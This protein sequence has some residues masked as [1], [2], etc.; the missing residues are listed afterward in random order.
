M[1]SVRIDSFDSLRLAVPPAGFDTLYE[2]LVSTALL[3]TGT[4]EITNRRGTSFPVCGDS[5]D[6]NKSAPSVLC[7][8]PIFSPTIEAYLQMRVSTRPAFQ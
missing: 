8:R 3:V 7:M 1:L 2:T 5:L 4:R 6:P